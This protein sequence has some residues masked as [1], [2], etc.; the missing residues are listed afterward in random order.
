MLCTV[1]VHVLSSY[2]PG[3]WDELCMRHLI[4]YVLLIYVLGEVRYS[5]YA[6]FLKGGGGGGGS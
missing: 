4:F 5:W 3:L 6:A 1:V 2:V